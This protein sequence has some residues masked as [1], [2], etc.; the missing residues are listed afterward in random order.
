MEQYE[1]R[2]SKISITDEG[3]TKLTS[4]FE[5]WLDLGEAFKIK[6]ESKNGT[7]LVTEEIT[8]ELYYTKEG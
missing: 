3:I 2:L 7:I 1:I 6:I 4:V 5:H 8:K